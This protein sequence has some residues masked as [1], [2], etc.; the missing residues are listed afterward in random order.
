M[1]QAERDEIMSALG[2][3]AETMK[4]AFAEDH[5]ESYLAAFDK[6]AI[7]SWPGMKLARGH[8]ELRELFENR[9]QLPPGSTLTIN[10]LELE[11]LS[12]DWA[13]A[14]GT[15][16]LSHADGS[17]DTLT[18]IALIGKTADGWKTFR[19]VVSP[20]QGSPFVTDE[21]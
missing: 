18:F 14:F 20:D 21:H 9:P 16:I 13:Y 12:S 19:E 3:L 17:T 10:P 4:R 5:V 11:V 2:A 8:G 6:D 1:N 15:D 7:V